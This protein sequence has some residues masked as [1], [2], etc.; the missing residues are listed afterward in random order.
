[1][2]NSFEQESSELNKIPSWVKN[3]A[4]WWANNFIDDVTFVQGVQYLIKEDIIKISSTSKNMSSS[5]NQIPS[6]VKN[7]AGWWA[8]DKIKDNEFVTSIK[9]LIENNI[10]KIIQSEPVT[11]INLGYTLTGHKIIFQDSPYFEKYSYQED[12]NGNG[13]GFIWYSA[14][15]EMHS[16]YSELVPNEK[17]VMIVPIFT[18]SAY[19]EP[20]FYNFYRGECT[21]CSTTSIRY[22][23]PLTYHSS[24][25]GVQIL[26]ILGYDYI[27]DIEVDKNPEIL[28]NYDKVIL[29]HNEY[30]TKNEFNAIIS[31][32]KVVYLYPNALYAEINV[33]YDKKTITLVKGHGYP[34]SDISNGFNWKNDNTHP[35]EFDINCNEWKFYNVDNGIM[36]N[37]YPENA[38]AQKIDILKKIK[39]Y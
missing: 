23:L 25:A 28:K 33:D 9:W 35:Y 32:P 8:T 26:S 21:K 12:F 6:W 7:N 10:V 27:T 37:C 29:L 3:N 13:F 17:T 20:G 4:G 11:E 39:E 34:K 2:L 36:L 16:L 24:H 31:H 1:M 30:V 18:S 38:I 19:W 14:K 5:S 22:E 15:P